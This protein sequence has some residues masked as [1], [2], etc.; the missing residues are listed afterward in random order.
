[1][2]TNDLLIFQHLRRELAGSLRHV[3][4]FVG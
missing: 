4:G 3:A 1:V 2:F